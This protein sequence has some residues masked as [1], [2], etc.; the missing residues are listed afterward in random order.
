M[1]VRQW[2]RLND[3]DFKALGMVKS[4]VILHLL[5]QLNRLDGQSRE[6]A[7]GL[8]FRLVLSGGKGLRY[9]LNCRNGALSWSD[10]AAFFR[11]ITLRGRS[12]GDIG[13]ML[14]GQKARILPLP[15]SL[16]FL[17]T[18]GTF[19]RL[20]SR[21]QDFLGGE[22]GK[23]NRDVQTLLLLEAA[24]C[25][26]ALVGNHDP[27]VSERVAHI[28]KGIIEVAVDDDPDW[29]RYLKIESGRFQY[30]NLRPG[31]ARARLIFR[32]RETVHAVLSGSLRAMTALGDGRIRIRGRI[33]MIQGLFPL[34]DRFSLFMTLK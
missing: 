11:D 27:Y 28:G 8:N 32:D 18:A 12:E 24:L 5:T 15:G 31:P 29:N 7:K 17:K 2:S 3:G 4:G 9:Q 30:L 10:R 23:N 22:E 19:Q 21:I 26:V 14:S 33:P 6:L 34:L 13:A 16:K 20:A 25:G 1:A